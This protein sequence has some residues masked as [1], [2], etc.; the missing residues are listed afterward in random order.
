[1]SHSSASLTCIIGLAGR[2]EVD[3]VRTRHKSAWRDLISS[4]RTG[5]RARA[6]IDAG[7]GA[8][9]QMERSTIEESVVMTISGWGLK[10]YALNGPDK[11]RPDD[12]GRSVG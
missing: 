7:T 4:G 10:A 11:A 12:V 9:C 1:V 5:H 8:R 6:T 3:L 2:R